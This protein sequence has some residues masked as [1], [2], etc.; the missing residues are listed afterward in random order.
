[1]RPF[2]LPPNQLHRFYRGG[3]AIARLRGIEGHDPYA[4]EDWVG[5]VNAAWGTEDEGLARLDDGRYVRDAVAADP[6]GFLGP[7]HVA[8][9]GPD[10]GLLVKLLDAAERLPVHAHP[11]RPFAAAYFASPFGK[12]EAWI[13]LGT[14][15][16]SAELWVGL[17]DDV[18]PAV[19]RDWIERQEVERLLASLNRLSVRAGDV[20]YL[21][22]GVPHAIGAGVFMAELQEPTDFSIVCEWTGFPIRPDDAHLGLGWDAAVGALDLHAHEPI[23]G[24]PDEARAF[25]WADGETDAP[26]RF[27]VLLVV[28]G[29]GE[30]AGEP[31]RAGDAWAVPAA[32]ADLGIGA[33]VRVLR[34]LAPDPAYG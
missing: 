16:P 24:L 5:A 23:H 13:V 25:F 7:E 22:A 34:C 4:P 6:E 14:R 1:M 8:R 30:V 10:P 31:A 2:A 9:Y 32:A 12:T 20:V 18:E 26:G 3:E 27:A 33:D 29:E 21:P 28:E 15:E 19:Y 17:R 11:D